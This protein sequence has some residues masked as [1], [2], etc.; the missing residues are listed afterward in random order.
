MNGSILSGCTFS[1][2]PLIFLNSTADTVGSVANGSTACGYTLVI[3]LLTG[4]VF[5]VGST[6]LPIT[7]ALPQSFIPI[8]SDFLGIKLSGFLGLIGGIIGIG[9]NV[10]GVTGGGITGVITG[11]ETGAG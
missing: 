6:T 8:G 11:G 7:W 1:P 4:I 3:G 10:S 5:I 9:S 2:L